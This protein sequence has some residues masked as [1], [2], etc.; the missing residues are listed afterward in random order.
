LK[1]IQENGYKEYKVELNNDKKTIDLFIAIS[2]LIQANIEKFEDDCELKFQ[3]KEKKLYD[4]HTGQ[5]RDVLD[6]IKACP[7]CG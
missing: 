4:P 6:L 2:Q 7:N 3:G 5:M 1:S